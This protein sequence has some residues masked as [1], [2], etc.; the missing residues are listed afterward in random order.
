MARAEGPPRG[1]RRAGLDVGAAHEPARAERVVKR[2]GVE[3]DP[4][5]FL[6]PSS[7]RPDRLAERAV[8]VDLARGHRARAE[9]V[10]EA[11]DGEAVGSAVDGRGTRKQPEPARPGGGA[12][13]AWP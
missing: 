5:R 6:N 2:G 7:S 12:V 4:D 8:E 13:D 11:P 10:L 3:D 9:L 1:A